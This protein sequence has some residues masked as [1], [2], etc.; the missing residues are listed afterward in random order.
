MSDKESSP[1]ANV[2][3]SENSG[4]SHVAKKSPKKS[5]VA[6]KEAPLADLSALSF[7]PAWAKEKSNKDRKQSPRR[8]DSGRSEKRA[9]RGRKADARNEGRG[10]RRNQRQ[11]GRGRPRDKR[12]RAPEVVLPEG[13]KAR[14]MPV[15]DGLDGLAKQIS[16]TG[17]THSVFDLAW[18]VLGGLERFHVIFDTEKEPLYRSATDSS[19]WLTQ[20]ECLSHFWASGSLEKYYDENITEVEAP[21]GN[22]QSVARCGLSR[23]LIA[24]PNHHAYQQTILDFHREK[25]G[26][27]SLEKYKQRITME[28][29]EEVVQ[30]WLDSMKKQT[31]WSPK[32][33]VATEVKSEDAP[34]ED[35]AEAP[36]VPSEEVII[37]LT[38]KRELEQHFLKH[39]FAEEYESGNTMSV[40]ANIEPKLLSPG[41]FAVQKNLVTESR[42]Y[43]GDLAS[44]LCRQMS[45]RHLAVFK[46][47]KRLH[48]GPARPK[49]VPKDLVMADR[50]TGLFNWVSKNPA[51]NI[52]TMWK[53]L[54]PKDIDDETKKLW[55]HDLHW[56]IN[57]GFLLLFSDGKLHAAKELDKP[58]PPAPKKKVAKKAAENKSTDT[59]TPPDSEK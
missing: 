50:P 12:E 34:A 51:G 24:P 46:W 55:Y 10:D 33:K 28:H 7:G 29:G 20:K 4:K 27:M 3:E 6:K 19:L 37:T 35:T 22:F 58:A 38:N 14:V 16:D 45:G 18:L 56:L 2:P 43:P 13:V 8:P 48:C 59:S 36:E 53:D 11:G 42:R 17:R 54:L 32:A 23:A 57:E 49:H 21:S 52:D 30:E 5:K 31:Q 39:G 41:L 9:P 40:R 1:D 25:F 47:K 15:E 44:I 26:N